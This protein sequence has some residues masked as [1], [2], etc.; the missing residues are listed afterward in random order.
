MTLPPFFQYRVILLLGLLNGNFPEF[1]EIL[2]EFEGGLAGAGASC[3]V[4]LFYLSV[5]I[6][7]E[8]VELFFDFS[9]KFLH[10]V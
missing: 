10:F 6:L 2:H 3:L 5:C 1:L 4:T 9:D 8:H 7:Y